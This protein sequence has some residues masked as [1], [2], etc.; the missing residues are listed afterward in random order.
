[1]MGVGHATS[2]AWGWMLLTSSSP[3]ALGLMAAPMPVQLSGAVVCAG[4]TLLLDFD[5]A[6]STAAYALPSLTLWRFTLIPSPTRLLAKAINRIFGH[7]K[8]VHGPLGWFAFTAVAFAASLLVIPVGDRVVSIG[9]GLVAV[10]LV[11]L[12]S[13][14]LGLNRV[15]ASAMSGVRSLG[16]LRSLL[17][18]NAL[19]PWFL[20]AGTA[21]LITWGMDYRWTWL[22]VA[23]FL[24]CVFHVL[25]DRLTTGGT[26]PFL[27]PLIDEPPAWL[28]SRPV[29]GR[30][31]KT[32]WKP[33]GYVAFPILGRTG[34]WREGLL[35]FVMACW[36]L[37][38]GYDAVV[39]ASGG[40]HVELGPI[41]RSALTALNSFLP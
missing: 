10:V 15:A 37:L 35:V 7:R 30:V 39:V 3:Y 13:K 32:F 12:A 40:K 41:A 21:G 5:H 38:L 26:R 16:L 11:A 6:D 20:A 4:A 14:S 36:T 9:S 24:G 29:L 23:V 1:M 2:G 22:P 8:Y 31:V 25:G 33:N 17:R 34:S 28:T 27:Y 18:D 19:G